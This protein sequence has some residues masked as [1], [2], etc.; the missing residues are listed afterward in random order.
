MNFCP[1]C[2]EGITPEQNFCRRCGYDLL[3]R[4][5]SIQAPSSSTSIPPIRGM[6][7]RNLYLIGDDGIAR[8]GTGF[9]FQL[10]PVSLAI[11]LAAAVVTLIEF[12][13]TI[14]LAVAFTLVLLPVSAEGRHRRLS[15]LLLIP[16]KELVSRRGVVLTPWSSVERAE[17]SGRTLRLEADGRRVTMTLGKTDAGILAARALRKVGARFVA[18]PSDGRRW[19]TPA[20]KFALFAL[21]LFVLTQAITIGASL[22]PFFPG[23]ASHYSGLYNSTEQGLSGISVVQLWGAIFFNNVQIALAS[24]VPGFGFLTLSLSSYNTGRVIQVAAAHF[25]ISA[26]KFLFVLYILPHS[27]VE[28][29]S[30][31]LAGALGIYAWSQWRRQSY[32]EFSNWRTRASTKLSLGF[33]LIALILAL[34]AALEVTEPYLGVEAL[35]LWG[36]LLL[37]GAYAYSRFRHRF[38][39]S[40]R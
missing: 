1:S 18:L 7:A 39:E 29:A 12:G 17:L 36:P 13:S 38:A 8:V 4:R 2:G 16:H 26:S 19:L 27:W 5:A 9:Y 25:S 15:K 3:R 21:G 11:G 37:G 34:A 20:A 30:Y 28:E 10:V 22:A 23:E 6:D 35:L 33:A 24:L 32:A 14:A 40:L 31:P